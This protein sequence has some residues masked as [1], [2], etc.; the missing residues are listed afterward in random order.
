MAGTCGALAGSFLTHALT[1]NEILAAYG[2]ALGE[3]A[4]FYGVIIVKEVS[5]DARICAT[6]GRAYGARDAYRTANALMLEFGLAEV[7]DSAV[8]RPLAMGVATNYLGREL[9]I[10]VGK[11]VADVTFYVPVIVAYEMRRR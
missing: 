6:A 3:N 5:S 4:A 11:L 9:G 7:L 8:I 2:G 10:V 1:G